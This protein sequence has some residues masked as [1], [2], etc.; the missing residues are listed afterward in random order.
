[1][2]KS[3]FTLIELLIV[4]SI[5]SMLAAMLLPALT[6]ARNRASQ[7]FCTGNLKQCFTATCAYISDYNSYLPFGYDASGAYS[8]YVSART[9]AWYY[10][11]APYLNVAQREGL[12]ESLGRVYAER[13]TKPIIFTCPSHKIPFPNSYPTSYAPGL[14]TASSVPAIDGLQKGKIERVKN[15]S[16]KAWINEWQYADGTNPAWPSITINEGNIIPGNTNNFFGMRHFNSGN[17]LFF[18]GHAAWIPFKDV[19]SPSSGQIIDGGI[20]DTYR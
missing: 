19:M 15:P 20:F 13:P 8:G 18:D 17:I 14:R 7:I 6:K 2:K 9:P 4:I 11:L 1:M 5:I 12:Y 16:A 10:Q 3:S